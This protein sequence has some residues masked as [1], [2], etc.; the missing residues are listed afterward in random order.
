LHVI[1]IN[2]SA[3]ATESLPAKELMQRLWEKGFRE[4]GQLAFSLS[5]RVQA[6]TL[7]EEGL[8]W[9][10]IVNKSR[11]FDLVVLSKADA[12]PGWKLFSKRTALRVIENAACP[13]LVVGARVENRFRCDMMPDAI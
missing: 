9:E 2:P 1:D 13:V 8:P 3:A 7:V 11:A 12:K 10:Q 4:M 6:Q 5:G